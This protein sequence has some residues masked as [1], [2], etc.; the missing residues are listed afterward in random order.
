MFLMKLDP[1]FNQVRSSLLMHKDLPDVA[2]VYRMLSQEESH[3]DLSKPMA[4]ASDKW[5]SSLNNKNTNNGKKLSYFCDHC[6]VSGHSFYRCFKIHS[7]PP[8]SRRQ[9]TKKIATN[10]H[11]DPP[12]TS[13][14]VKETSLTQAQFNHL[15][16]LLG[17][18]DVDKPLDVDTSTNTTSNLA[19]ISYFTSHNSYSHWIIDIGATDHM[20]NNLSVFTNITPITSAHCITIPDGS[21]LTISKQRDILLDNEITLTKVLYVPQL[22]FNL[23]SAS[24]LCLDYNCSILFNST[25]CYIQDPTMK[26]L[27]PL[28]K[29]SKGLYYLLD[30]RVRPNACDV[31]ITTPNKTNLA[32]TTSMIQQAKLLHLRLGHAPFEKIKI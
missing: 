14:D 22:H 19:G 28:G 32:Y 8:N 31:T 15:L 13:S 3:K 17:K 1:Q 12:P 7:Y 16:T 4:F 30:K 6:K 27:L 26:R 20:C 2:E 23:I 10:M 21:T 29:F 9:L 18:K 11:T 24:K 25:S 5:K